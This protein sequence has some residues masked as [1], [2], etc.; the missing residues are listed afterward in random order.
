M[1]LK[2]L[3]SV[4][5]NINNNQVNLSIKRKVLK[6]LNISQDELLNTELDKFLDRHFK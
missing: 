6:H 5:R 3:V 4:T 1:R 2:D